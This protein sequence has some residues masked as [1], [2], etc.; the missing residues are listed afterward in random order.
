MDNDNI[1]LEI[2]NELKSQIKDLRDEIKKDIDSHKIE[3]DNHIDNLYKKH[4]TLK[5]KL[6]ILST[7]M[8]I[9]KWLGSL[10]G[11]IS[12]GGVVSSILQ[13]VLK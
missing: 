5:E 3:N 11:V 4:D 12:I 8:K 9:L 1:I 6:I 7:E 13:G 10:V 2:L